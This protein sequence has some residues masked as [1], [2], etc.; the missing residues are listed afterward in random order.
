MYMVH[1]C[2]VYALYAGV[3]SFPGSSPAFCH[4]HVLYKNSMRQ[5]AGEELGNEA[6]WVYVHVRALLLCVLVCGAGC[7]YRV[8]CSHNKR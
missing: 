5:K 8:I 3:A 6:M 4:I 2:D 1:V 7:T